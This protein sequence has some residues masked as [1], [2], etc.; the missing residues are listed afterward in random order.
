MLVRVIKHVPKQPDGRGPAG[1]VPSRRPGG[2]APLCVEEGRASP[3]PAACARQRRV[4]A[5]RGVGDGPADNF[6]TRHSVS[7]SLAVPSF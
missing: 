2:R 5:R 7:P 1:F 4:S 3:A 6:A